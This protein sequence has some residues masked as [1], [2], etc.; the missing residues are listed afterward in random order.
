MAL[1]GLFSTQ[2]LAQQSCTYECKAYLP[3]QEYY[4]AGLDEYSCQA[5]HEMC[6]LEEHCE[7]EPTS[8]MCH[9]YIDQNEAY[10]NQLD[11]HS[12]QIEDWICYWSNKK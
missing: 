2:I 5:E 8:G 9:A 3:H 7:D 12:C 6:Y 4:C 1:F 11:A 10:C